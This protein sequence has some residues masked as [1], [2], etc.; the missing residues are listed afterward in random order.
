MSRLFQ[1]FLFVFALSS[2]AFGQVSKLKAYI[3]QKTYFSPEI[4]SYAEIQFQFVG[5]TFH[6]APVETGLQTKV[7][8][9]VNA[10]NAS[11]DTVAS[12]AYVLES[13]IMRDS[14]IEDFF[15]IVRFKLTPGSYAIH[16]SLRD[17]VGTSDAMTGQIELD[18]PLYTNKTSV[19]D[20]LIAEVAFKTTDP[21]VFSKSGYDII[22]R[23]SN[24]YPS[25][26][27]GLPYYVELYNTE[28]LNDTVFAFRQRIISTTDN[29]E[30]PQ[31][32]RLSKLKSETIVPLMRNLDI[33][34]LPSGS[35]RLE[36]AILDRNSILQG[37]PS[38]Y[39][40]E[41]IN[42]VEAS[43]NI[44]DL[45]LDPAFQA[46]ITDDSVAYY[47][48]SLIPIARPAE[49]RNILINIKAGN[50]EVA[51]KHIQQFWVQTAGVNASS[52]W[53]NYKDQVMMV[54]KQYGNNFQSGFETD[55]GRVFL[56]YGPP[57]NII[58]R[59]TSPAEYPYEIWHY[60]KIKKYSNK[61]FVFYNPDL[62]NKGYRLL[63]SD[64]IGEQQNYRWPL[65]LVMRTSTNP[66][67]DNPKSG[68]T[69]QY[70]GNALQDYNLTR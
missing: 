64:M 15:D 55:R 7:A 27:T 66:D 9:V 19:S 43:D 68:T 70:G 60:Y 49:A 32:T 46:S 10:V 30:M 17:L 11:N 4:G 67:I 51:R 13:P 39:Y 69:P 58:S 26:L 42:E 37:N 47:L 24:F 57:N 33:S 12:D 22:P 62:I 6:Y 35:Y 23:I 2:S 56:Q 48:A 44:D 16:I 18:V 14:I 45:V 65:A 52:A 36:L 40:F 31:F 54:E 20:V 38:S 50:K 21:S 5:Y 53:L 29:T 1:L 41:R 25:D 28:L 63:H 8:I 61:R 34:T 3:D 59:E